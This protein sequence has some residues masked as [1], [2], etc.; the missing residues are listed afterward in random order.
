MQCYGSGNMPTNRKDIMR[1]L[2]DASARGLVIVSVTQCSNGSVSGLYATG[3][4]LLDIGVIPGNDMTPEAALTKLAYVLAKDEWDIDTKR[5]MM[6]TNI[7]GEMTVMNFKDDGWKSLTG[8]AENESDNVNLIDAVAKT[9]RVTST[10]EI[11]GLTDVL[12]PSIL[13]AAVYT[14]DIR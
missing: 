4:A 6:Q 14:G 8:R 3:K 2:K 11:E 13:C 10:E 5:Q 9:L 7:A 12:M 1:L